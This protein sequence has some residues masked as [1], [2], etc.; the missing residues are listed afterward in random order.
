MT[1]EFSGCGLRGSGVPPEQ[2]DRELARAAELADARAAVRCLSGMVDEQVQTEGIA[3]FLFQLL[4]DIDTASDIAKSDDA[5]YRSLVREAH[6]RRFEVAT[7]D[8]YG[9][10]WRTDV[11]ANA[12]VES[13]RVGVNMADPV[14]LYED[15]AAVEHER[16]AH[17]QQ[18]LHS[19]CITN[20]DGS[21]TVP[22]GY[23]AQLERL[24]DTPYG[25]L[26]EQEKASDREQVDRYWHLI[27]PGE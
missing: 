5:L 2:A 13:V 20:S 3:R 14:E 9:V 23:V 1:V 7:T 27:R 18:Y 16:W 8:G 4:D 11:D 25:Q 19:K 24:I 22:A 26:T 21:L 17:W 6:R 12:A 15:L 10:S